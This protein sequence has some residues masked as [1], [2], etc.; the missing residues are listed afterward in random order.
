MRRSACR[1]CDYLAS[2]G[3]SDA[4]SDSFKA[5]K[6]GGRTTAM[7]TGLTFPDSES[8]RPPERDFEDRR[9]IL[10]RSGK[11]G[12]PAPNTVR[13][14]KTNGPAFG[15]HGG[16]VYLRSNSKLESLASLPMESVLSA[17]AGGDGLKYSRGIHARDLVVDVP[18]GT[19]VRERVKTDKTTIEGR[20][21]FAPKFVYQFLRDKDEFLLCE[22]GK[23]GVA[24][25]TFKKGDG[26]VG[27]NGE[28]KSIDLE[29]RLVNDV[30]LIGVANSGKSSIISSL[31]SA[32]TQIG[33]EPYTTSR[34]HFGTLQYRDG[35]VVSILDLPAIAQGAVS[36]KTHG[37][38]VLRH[39]YRSK[40]ILYCV[41]MSKGD[42]FEQLEVLHTELH[43]DKRADLRS[44]L[45]VATKCDKANSEDLDSLFNKAQARWGIG[46]VG[47]SARFG[48]GIPRLVNTI[49]EILHGQ[50]LA[51][52]RDRLLAVPVD[53]SITHG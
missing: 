7:I 52:N 34:P 27:L 22:G 17:D 23:G 42:A 31:T 49:R 33:P 11:G 45:I 14:Q 53:T 20:R 37:M 47:T 5:V 6:L 41:D 40:L 18:V 3:K 9:Q 21:I 50:A 16:S 44:E 1:L 24:P 32:C 30:S 19:I 43:S 4:T 2:Q 8:F 46:V 10:F 39:V 25:L 13:G 15:G 29:L 26:R 28:K 48:V 51:L 35:L 36:D 12:N 38:R